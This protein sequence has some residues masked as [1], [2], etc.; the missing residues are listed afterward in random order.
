M[1]NSVLILSLILSTGLIQAQDID[2]FLL[3]LRWSTEDWFETFYQD[4][5]GKY[6]IDT[7]RIYPTGLSLGG[8]GTWF[9]SAKYPDIF[10]AIAPISG[11]TNESDYILEN[12]NH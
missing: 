10:A 12:I 11:F 4:I 7:T 9:L 8:E 3:H 5:I 2:T 1:K 6:R